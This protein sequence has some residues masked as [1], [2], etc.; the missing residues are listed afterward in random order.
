L[1]H[2]VGH[3]GKHSPECRGLKVTKVVGEWVIACSSQ[4]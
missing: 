4:A 1:V 3:A 2:L